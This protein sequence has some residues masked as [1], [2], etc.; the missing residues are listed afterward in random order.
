MTQELEEKI[1]QL[2]ETIQ[3][4][5]D[6]LDNSIENFNAQMTCQNA[7]MSTVLE[8]LEQAQAENRNLTILVEEMLHSM[9]PTKGIPET[10][11]TSKKQVEK[12]VELN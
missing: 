2:C 4:K 6:E 5:E 12:L 1:T 8:G 11:N 9:E 7:R 10:E 3:A